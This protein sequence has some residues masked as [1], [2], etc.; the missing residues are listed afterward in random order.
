VTLLRDVIDIPERV[1]QAD[2]VVGLAEGVA[3]SRRT[4]AQYVFTEQVVECLDTSLGLVAEAV[5]S[6]RS[7]AAFLHGSFGSGKSHFMA[8]LHQ[9]LRHD[10]DARAVPELAKVLSRHDPLL[11]GKKVLPLT[12]HLIG[13][14]DLESA[15]LGGYVRQVRELHPEAPL[16]AVHRSDDLLANADQQ[17]ALLGDEKFFATLG[18]VMAG[19]PAVS[20]GLGGLGRATA[21]SRGW[22]GA[23]YAAAR[24]SLAGDPARNRLVSDLVRTMFPAF[25]SSTDYLDLDLG[26]TVL[27]QHASDLGYD[28]VVLFLDELVLWLASHLGN[29]E[30]VSNEGAKLAKLVEAQDSRRAVPLVGFIA[31]QRDLV[32]FLGTH[33]PGAEKAAFADVFGWSRGRFEDVRLEDRN[34]PLIAEKRLLR[35]VDDTARAVLDAAFDAVDRRPEVWDVLLTGGQVAGSGTGSDQE[36]FRRT[37]PFSPALVST[38][39]ALSQALQ[40]E[41]TALK[42][43]L[44]LLVTGRDELQVNDVI[45]VGDLFDVLVDDDVQTVTPE[46]KKPFDTARRLYR[47]RLRPALLDLHQATEDQVADLPRTAPFRT[48]DRLVK[49]LLLSALAPDVPALRGLTASRLAALN[50]GT[51]TSWLPGEEVS[52]AVTKMKQLGALVSEVR[53]GEGDDPLISLEL[54]DV[55]HESVLERARNV[56]NEGNRRRTLRELVWESLGVQEQSTLDGVQSETLVWRGRRTVVDLVFGNVRDAAELPDRA[57]LASE[58]RWKLVVDYPF[59]AEGQSPRSDLSRVEQMRAAGVESRTLFWLPAFLSRPRMEDLGTFVVLDHVLGGSG[60]RFV[61][62]ADHLSPVDRDQARNLLRQRHALLRERLTDC[63]KQCYGSARQTEADVDTATA[64]DTPFATLERG[65]RPQPPV[66]G[67]LRE[68]F[69]NLLD[70]ALSWSAPAHPRFEPG[71]QEV[72]PGD[73]RRLL[74]YCE[75]ACEAPAGRLQGVDQKDRP[76]L[77]RLCGPLEVGALHESVFVLDD[78]SFPWTRRL[79]QAA[80]RDGHRDSFPVRALLG[81]L[82]EPEVR[83]LSPA[84]AALVLQVFALK[85]DLAWYR[86]GMPV[87]A[88]ALEGVRP[89]HEL[90]QPHLPAED[91]WRAAVATARDVLGLEVTELR[92]ATNLTRLGRAARELAGQHAE[93]ARE[94]ERLLAQHRDDLGV[95]ASKTP[96]R[97]ATAAAVR[98]LLDRLLVEADD[99]A[100]VEVLADASTPTTATAAFRS[101]TTSRAV[102]RALHSTQWDVVRALSTITDSRADEARSLQE[103]LADTA[104]RDELAAGLADRLR[105]V[106]AAAVRL[107]TQTAPPGTT[108][109]RVVPGAKQVPADQAGAAASGTYDGPPA[110]AAEELERLRA[111]LAAHPDGTATLTWQVRP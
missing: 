29:R 59:D 88:P 64:T 5:R 101:M 73:L 42:V 98:Q 32:E 12:Y 62:Y 89:E 53:V 66:G 9:L 16:P 96:D 104:G 47:T 100:V 110:G 83:G 34:L 40:R 46:M 15:V 39:V 49:T 18:A 102:A 67:T 75:R 13:A 36:A 23:S 48:D 21:G 1:T 86:E 74:E 37:Y 17:R 82:D 11:Q 105:E 3:D 41:R 35:P 65:F 93:Q 26:F 2:F 71:D 99:A 14:K 63:L 76:S 92:S 45:P 54:T 90:R 44:R 38:L 30:F 68:A 97:Y 61:S 10:P 52:V 107:L 4:L 95:G 111:A 56:D 94:L 20:S 72:R 28:A 69:R 58:D 6:G 22:D 8:V 106:S 55:D 85:Q 57:L 91:P 108:T 27:A 70:Q 7:Q 77:K 87:E 60:D 43:M 31:R 33:V 24:Q 78:S 79:L 50:H 80:A 103:R 84:V 19:A 25:S 109:V 51:I 81:Y